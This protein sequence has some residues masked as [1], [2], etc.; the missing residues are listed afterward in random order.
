MDMVQWSKGGGKEFNDLARWLGYNE[1]CIFPDVL[2]D[3]V[4]VKNKWT[5][6]TNRFQ[7]DSS[8]RLSN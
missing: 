1:N 4:V 8:C 7:L 2:K 3:N 6:D 5:K